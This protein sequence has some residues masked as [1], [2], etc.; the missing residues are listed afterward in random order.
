MNIMRIIGLSILVVFA[1]TTTLRPAA[2]QATVMGHVVVTK[3][4]SKKRVALPSYEVRGMATGPKTSG[5][6]SNSAP[7]IDEMSRV[8]VYL[9]GPGLDPGPPAN[10]TL[11]QKNQHFD[12]EILAVPVGSTVSFPNADPI[13][14]NVFS[15]SKIKNFDLGY[16]PEGQTRGV[17]F[18]RPGIVQVYCHLH[19][20]MSAAILVVPNSWWVR[21][22]GDGS[23]SLSGFPPG[24]YRLVAWHRSAG[25]FTRQIKVSAGQTI[26]L[27]IVIP[28]TEL[29]AT[30]ALTK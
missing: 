24:S 1:S 26:S 8:I 27:D 2:N 5:K 22:S 7:E 17:K 11:S 6:S 25:L 16:Y 10:V 19:A 28:L 9:E 12:P 18:D 30:S 29:A 21:P 23:F 13:F 4:L 20:D 15:L 14:H 3:A